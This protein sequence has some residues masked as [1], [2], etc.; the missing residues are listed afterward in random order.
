[1]E[2]QENESPTPN[3]QSE[4]CRPQEGRAQHSMIDDELLMELD[5]P[6]SDEDRSRLGATQQDGSHLPL[7]PVDLSS[8]NLTRAGDD[9]SNARRSEVGSQKEKGEK[10]NRRKGMAN[11][12][13]W[14][15]FL[16]ALKRQ[17]KERAL[18]TTVLPR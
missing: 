11:D 6:F 3:Q 1:M 9:Q 15:N 7:A 10:R 5:D 14:T 13:T 4:D 12:Q 18:S 2:D 8:T 16:P 17:S